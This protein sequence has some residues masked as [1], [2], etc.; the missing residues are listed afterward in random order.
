MG[1]ARYLRTLV[2]DAALSGPMDD[3]QPQMC[4]FRKR[5]RGPARFLPAHPLRHPRTRQKLRTPQPQRENHL[6]D[7]G[8]RRPQSRMVPG[9]RSRRSHPRRPGAGHRSQR[10]RN[11]RDRRNPNRQ[12][13]SSGQAQ[14]SPADSPEHPRRQ[15]HPTGTAQLDTQ[16]APGADSKPLTVGVSAPGKPIPAPSNLPAHPEPPTA[17]RQATK[18]PENRH[19]LEKKDLT[20]P[21]I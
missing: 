1:P 7:Q 10:Q 12:T 19:K 4:G 2:R 9:F 15:P 3:T 20:G 6:H 14:E 16:P 8:Q 21:L 17:P 18:H 11:H 5:H 13:C